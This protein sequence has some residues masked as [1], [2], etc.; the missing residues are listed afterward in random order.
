MATLDTNTLRD[1]VD[2]ATNKDVPISNNPFASD[3]LAASAAGTLYSA[4]ASGVIHDVTTGFPI[5][6]G[7]TGRT[8]IGDLVMGVNGL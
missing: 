7:P 6:V 5:P 3:S 8:Q 2:V 1:Q 4:D